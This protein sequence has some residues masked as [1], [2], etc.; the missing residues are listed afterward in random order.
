VCGWLEKSNAV[1]EKESSFSTSVIRNADNKE[2]VF[3]DINALAFFLFIVCA[4]M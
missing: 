1:S 2:A 4:H 3:T